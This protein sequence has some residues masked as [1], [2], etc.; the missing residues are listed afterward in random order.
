MSIIIDGRRAAWNL[1]DSMMS[2]NITFGL[3]RSDIKSM[4]PVER[5][6][7]ERIYGVCPGVDL[8][9]IETKSGNWQPP[10]SKS[11]E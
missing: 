11:R 4:K 3:L 1:P 9:L 6:E 10:K 7:A 2:E 8:V 5:E